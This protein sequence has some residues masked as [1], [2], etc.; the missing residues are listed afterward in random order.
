MTS[1]GNLR[2]IEFEQFVIFSKE[3]KELDQKKF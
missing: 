2:Q 1:I 3:S